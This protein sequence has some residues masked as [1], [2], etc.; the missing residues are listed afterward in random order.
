MKRKSYLITGGTGLLGA[1]LSRLLEEAGHEVRCI[2]GD[3]SDV[4]AVSCYR[5]LK[6][7]VDWV[8]HT[9]AMTN[10]DQCERE[11]TVCWN[12]N[13]NGTRIVRDLA[14]FLG[15]RFLYTSTASVFSGE[16]GDYREGDIPYPKNFYN[17]TKAVGDILA[18][19]YEGGL[20]VRFNLMGIHPAGSRGKNFLEWL[21]DTV[22]ADKDISLFTD[23]MI[24]PLSNWTLAEFIYHITSLTPRERI[25][26]LASS[27]VWSK[28]D[29]G[30]MVMA[31]FPKYQGRVRYILSDELSPGAYRPKE[32]WLNTDR[33]KMITNLTMPLLEEDVKKIFEHIKN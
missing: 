3:I 30:K 11:R 13:V 7:A 9:A 31:Y 27:G 4:A 21:V 6:G 22:R 32:M 18:N 25:L 8:I 20:V 33:T 5:S 17:F 1:T 29:I 23:V 10:V 19:E 24:N 12:T 28:A 15:A 16:K 14:R 26:H 2:E